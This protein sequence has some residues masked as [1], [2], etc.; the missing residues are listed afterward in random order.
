MGTR[1][2]YLKEKMTRSQ[3]FSSCCFHKMITL[4]VNIIVTGGKGNKRN[5]Y[6]AR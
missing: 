1:K 2:I 5:T 6:T 4:L 3:F